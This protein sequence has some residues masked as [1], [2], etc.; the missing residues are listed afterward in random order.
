MLVSSS[1]L[2]RTVS[3]RR[4]DPRM[5][6]F[7]WRGGPR[8]G[9]NYL[10]LSLHFDIRSAYGSLL[11]DVGAIKRGSGPRRSSGYEPARRQESAAVGPSRYSRVSAAGGRME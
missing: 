1:E 9:T 11:R 5:A 2:F 8:R 7:A 4:V 10:H 6:D 3:R